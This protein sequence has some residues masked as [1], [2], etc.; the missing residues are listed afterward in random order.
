[1]S[2]GQYRLALAAL[3]TALVGAAGPLASA[4]QAAAPASPPPKGEVRTA[5]VT[6]PVMDGP[7]PPSSPDSNAPASEAPTALVGP[8]V[9]DTVLPCGVRVI[10]AQDVT[11]PV[12]A[13]V[14]AIETGTEDDPT[15]APGLVHAL[16]YHLLQGNREY[17]PSGIA[18]AVHST[19][20]TTGLAIGPAQIRFE[21]LVPASMLEEL[22]AAEATRLRAPSVSEALWKDTLRWAR[23]SRARMW[24]VPAP[25]RASAHQT[26]GL[27]HDGNGVSAAVAGLSERAVASQLAERF[28]YDR[29]SLIIVGPEASDLVLNTVMTAF[30]DLPAT[31]RR[32]RDRTTT[33]HT[34]LA[35]RATAFKGAP[36]AFVWPIPGNARAQ[37]WA[38][39]VCGTLNSLRRAADEPS[40][41]RLRCAI[42][43]DPRRGVMLL[44]ASGTDDPQAL[45]RERLQRVG[46]DEAGHLTKQRTAVADRLR[47]AVRLPLALARHLA[48]AEQPGPEPGQAPMR[49]A[50]DL[51]GAAA[52]LEHT[53]VPASYAHLL[54]IGAATVARDP[55]KPAPVSAP[56]GDE[57]AP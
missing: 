45:V 28:G 53:A 57:P 40:R 37:A 39:V 56:G 44:K 4:S 24:S 43:D 51:L 31:P 34:G 35:P 14:L 6:A 30:A 8:L 21:S 32:A 42:D 3:A 17:A 18:R 54:D 15:E 1:M 27:A 23:R 20:G 52:V 50:A 49:A 26:D 12:A 46:D 13:V 41:V 11:L 16:A 22:V 36:G 29:A 47:Y 2:P 25:L 10:I 7:A 33:P 5:P 48:R 19:G 55:T 9:V 38:E